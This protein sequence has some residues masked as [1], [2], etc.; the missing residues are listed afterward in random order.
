MNYAHPN[1]PEK[2][3]LLV[4]ALALAVWWILRR[5]E[6][7][8]GGRVAPWQTLALTVCVWGVAIGVPVAVYMGLEMISGGAR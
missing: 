6:N 2:W 5:V 1:D 8:T 7:S 3:V 4:A